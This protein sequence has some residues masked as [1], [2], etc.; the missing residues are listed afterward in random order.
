MR[1]DYQ[2]LELLHPHYVSGR[3]CVYDHINWT[4]WISN[5]ELLDEINREFDLNLKLEEKGEVDED[6]AHDV[7]MWIRGR[8]DLIG[9][10]GTDYDRNI[11]DIYK[12]DNSDRSW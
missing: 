8:K 6:T 4:V 11:L 9:T 3:G 10:Y 12:D 1:L 5:Q 2:I 7:W